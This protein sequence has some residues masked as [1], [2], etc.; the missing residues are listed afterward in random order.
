MNKI[1][2][3]FMTIAAIAA[4]ASFSS[5]KEKPAPVVPPD[6]EPTPE[7]A[8]FTIDTLMLTQGSF[9]FSILPLDKDITYYFNLISKATYDTFATPEAL[10]DYDLAFIS[11]LAEANGMSMEQLLENELK[12]GDQTWGYAALIPDTEYVFYVYGLDIDGTLLTE[13]N[14]FPVKTP[15]AAFVQGVTF[16]IEESDVD[17]NSMNITFEP[18]SM[19]IFY[20]VN[21][22]TE[23]EYSEYC[24]SDP[25]N[26]GQFTLDF[27]EELRYNEDDAYDYGV[28]TTA[29][30]VN[31]VT[32]AG[33]HTEKFDNLQPDTKYYA[34]AVGLANDFTV[35]TDVT[36]KEVRTAQP[37]MNEYLVDSEVI[38]DDTY[39]ATISAQQEES[40]VS[41]MLKSEYLEGYA[42]D[43][44]MVADLYRAYSSVI[45]RHIH[46]YTCLFEMN[47]LVP[48]TDYTLVIYAC[49]TDGTP[50]TGG[51][52]NVKKHGV[53]TKAPQMSDVSYTLTCLNVGRDA[54]DLSV[55]AN[56]YIANET[57]MFNYL[58][59][60]EYDA[61]A[62]KT[63]GL[64][65]HMNAFWD[66]KYEEYRQSGGQYPMDEFR[67][68]NLITGE[69]NL[70]G[71]YE[72]PRLVTG[73]TYVFYLFGMVA[74]GSFTTEPFTTTVTMLADETSQ[75]YL[76]FGINVSNNL[77]SMFNPRSTTTYSLWI[78]PNNTDYK[79][80]Y[81][82]NFPTC[83]KHSSWDGNDT[84]EITDPEDA[85]AGKTKAEI[86]ELLKR[87][88]PVTDD[89]DIT[90]F[91]YEMEHGTTWYSYAVIYDSYGIPSDVYKIT[92]NVTAGEENLTGETFTDYKLVADDGSL[93]NP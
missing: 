36:V 71:T 59:K 49:E 21:L 48:S 84:W 50:K 12:Y 52:F 7:P 31:R 6:P 30:F 57:F 60:S 56:P 77:N 47:R 40:Y 73:E 53:R 8:E 42:S 13:L 64:K 29:E 5:C 58:R 17:K 78:Y 74:D 34:Y 38:E 33:K 75:A 68:N 69:Q 28:F 81:Y 25:K 54:L 41:I 79:V 89:P 80:L 1:K 66:T 4:M 9:E 76:T 90:T 16:A 83:I 46:T 86:I 87:E 91:F 19:E 70:V 14:A 63:K 45:S 32:F 92:H 27:L 62:D 85:W 35:M 24:G 39:S 93:V 88:T 23:T 61:M 72:I 26:L 15:A 37:P 51:R 43:E 20:F 65:E 22:L 18:S 67:A 82:K 2:N 44:D 10:Q 11:A 55:S 3:I